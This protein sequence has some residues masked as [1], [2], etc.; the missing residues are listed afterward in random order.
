MH[1]FILAGGFATRLWPLTEQRAKPLL[2]LAGK[3]I[4][5]HIVEGISKDIPITVSTNA[6]FR[7]GFHSWKETMPQKNI[8]ILIEDTHHDDQKLG[9]LGAVAQWLEQGKIN[10]DVLL[11]TGDNYFGFRIADFLSAYHPATPIL[12]AHDIADHERAKAFGTVIIQNAEPTGSTGHSAIGTVVDFQEKPP[13]PQTTLVSTGCSILP[14][15][16]LSILKEFAKEHPDNVGGIFEKLLHRKQQVE[17]FTFT[18]PW[19]DIG[20]FDAY[21]AAT[22]ELVGEQTVL[23]KGAHCVDTQCT[24][25]NV[26]GEQSQAVGSTLE[27]V[28]LFEQCTVENCTLRN[29]IVD[30]HCTL[31]GVD[32][33]GK[34]LRAGT[35]LTVG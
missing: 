3:P 34:M 6:V 32:L 16:V 9:A 23:E 21:L 8:E 26:I 19:F 7:E 28:V 5:T 15:S 24:G 29:C 13:N 20:S 27:N 33:E 17:C 22:K 10:E 30:N 1:A 18:E 35:V 31:K 25:S 2:P 11:L 4:L 14:V 12:A